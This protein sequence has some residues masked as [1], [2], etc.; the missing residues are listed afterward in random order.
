MHLIRR[1]RKYFIYNILF[2][3]ITFW[4]LLFA[5]SL[6][7]YL[8]RSIGI[9]LH[10][11]TPFL[12]FITMKKGIAYGTPYGVAS[13]FFFGILKLIY[14][15]I[16]LKQATQQLQIEKQ[17]AELNYLK[18]QTNPHFLFN[19]LNNIYSLARDKSDLAPESILKLSKILRFIRRDPPK[20]FCGTGP[21]TPARSVDRPATHS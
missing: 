8:W 21:P 10:I 15:N 1:K 4:V 16:K 11:Y 9:G 6:G 5:Y 7:M 14:D 13:F 20:F 12:S 18:S 17:Q 3:I 19:T 2:G